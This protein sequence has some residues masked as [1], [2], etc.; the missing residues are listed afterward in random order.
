MEND[1]QDKTSF[2]LYVKSSIDDK[3]TLYSLI[4]TLQD[5]YDQYNPIYNS[6]LVDG[7][8]YI[9]GN[10]KETVDEYNKRIKDEYDEKQLYLKL[11]EKYEHRDN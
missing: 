7:T 6:V 10:R 11:K 9:Y 5:V 1:L 8:V 4:K 3:D 2:I